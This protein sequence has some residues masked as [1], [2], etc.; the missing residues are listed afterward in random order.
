MTSTD[1]FAG[2]D[3]LS[4]DKR[5]FDPSR[6]DIER[7]CR[8]FSI[9]KLKSYEKEKGVIVSHSNFFV[10]AATSQ[11]EYALKFY[12]KEAAKAVTVEYAINRL[13]TARGF[14]T[15]AMYTGPQGRPTMAS[16][17][18]LAVCYSYVNGSPAWKNIRQANTIRQINSAML[19]LKK[20]LSDSKEHILFR[21][22]ETLTTTFTT[23]TRH[24]QSLGDYEQKKI[25][26]AS[27]L[28][29][30]RKFRQHRD[31]FTRQLLHNNSNLTNFL[32]YK[33]VLYVLDLSHI[34]EDYV[35]SDLASLVLSGFL[36]N[37]SASTIKSVVKDHFMQHQTRPEYTAVLDI[38]V[39][40]RL[41]KEYL[42]NIEREQSLK[43]FAY[44]AELRSSY[45]YYLSQRK[46]C[47][48]QVL[49]K[50]S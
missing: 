7:I 11:G 30:F 13:M 6:D 47:I 9:G 44:P 36:F 5:K 42:K 10:F 29:A 4:L 18:R 15:P 25:I 48:I 32:T 21:K 3:H 17:G 24:S 37:L 34:Q 49:R 12:P 26:E 43:F 23:V 8:F 40:I 46:E 14:P 33:K 16:H 50:L 28:E 20:I 38:L 19:S 45:T 27:L 39:K 35:L 2:I 22:S 41:I 1:L 31:L